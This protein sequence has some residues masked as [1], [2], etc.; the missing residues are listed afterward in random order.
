MFKHACLFFLLLFTVIGC[1][2]SQPSRDLSHWPRSPAALAGKKTSKAQADFFAQVLQKIETHQ[3][4]QARSEIEAALTQDPDQPNLWVIWAKILKDQG[5]AQKALDQISEQIQAH[6][7]VP[8][9]LVAR[10]LF[11]TELGYHVSA[12]EDLERV[13]QKTDYRSFELLWS[14]ALIRLK[15]KNI[16]SSYEIL[17]EALTH[18]PDK[19]EAL[20]LKLRIEF[21]LKRWDKAM[22]TGKRLLALAGDKLQY[23]QLYLEILYYSGQR[24]ALEEKLLQKVNEF[25][26]EPW[27]ASYLSILYLETG[28]LE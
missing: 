9:L 28:R 3:L 26:Q 13:Y 4:E 8:S 11:L 27:Y 6:P 15:E 10:G 22:K 16:Y 21:Q 2:S 14:L 23:Q 7:K 1:S 18:R 20:F 17:S 19:P 25:P 24:K 5:Q 12:K